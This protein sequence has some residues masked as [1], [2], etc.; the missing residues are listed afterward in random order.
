MP[1]LK[2]FGRKWL[3]ATDDLVYP[4]LFELF[5]RVV[6]LILI[7]IVC[8]RYY[9]DTWNCRLGGELVR[10]YLLGEA[11]ML[12]IVTLLI[13]III[14]HSARGNIMDTHARCYVEPLLMIK[15]LMLLPEIG[16]NVL[17]TM[18]I[19]GQSVECDHESYSITVVEAL[20][21]FD[22]ILIGLSIFG[23]ALVFDPIGSLERRQLE[24]SVEHGKIS[25]LWLRRFKFLWWMRKDESANET[26]QHVA[27]LL[28]ALFRGTDLVPSDVIAGCI[29][30]RVRQKRET[31]ELRKLNL[32]TRPK[33]TSDSSEIFSG[34]PSWMSLEA[35]HHFLQLSI[36]SY[37]WLF[38]IYQ[39]LCTGCFRLIRGMTCCAC[40]RRKRNIILD[41]NCC[42]CYLSGI[43]YLSKLSEEDIL[44]ASLKNHLCEIPFCVIADHKTANIVVAIRGSL[45]LRDLITD[46]AA[47]S[48]SFEC[49]GL[50]PNSTAHRGMIIGVKI[51]LKQLENY[52]V[53][54]RAFATYPNY[55]LTITGHSLG[56]GLA[57]LLGLLIRPRYPDLR[58]YA[59]ATPAGLLSRDAARITEEFALT[60]GLGDDLVMRLS[61]DSIE[62]LRTSLLTTLRDCRLPKYRVVLNGFGYALF[63]VSENDLSKTWTNYN[64][65]STIPGQSPLLAKSRD[66]DNQIIER[67]ITKRRYSKERLFNAGRILHITRCKLENTEG[68]SKK[69]LAKERKYEMRWAQAEEFT[70][71][72]VMPRMLLDHLPENIE[73]ALS[74]LL[75]QQN[76]I[77]YYFDP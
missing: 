9:E 20:V 56:A 74:T 22:W 54:E 42:L 67:D 7:G 6:W 27:G 52:K 13:L 40:F 17:G 60:I 64:I 12:S 38:V 24:S 32:I 72:S 30:L 31:H 5:I 58:V 68:K 35:A 53:L 46:I 4:G 48:D 18:W 71:L 63:G 26:F 19:F 39:H 1:A 3:A 8:A 76:D 73:L 15:I 45:S 65:I 41:D 34:T 62:N 43:K 77:P 49:P 75:E 69:Q 61:V 23:I 70:K 33:Y 16:W 47:A 14:R 21:F 51:I 57:I 36:A 66:T 29:L 10:V 2:L 37:G 25:R 55:N 11:V 59:F 44:F 50:P 28:S